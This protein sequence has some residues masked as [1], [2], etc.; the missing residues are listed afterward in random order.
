MSISRQARKFQQ[1]QSGFGIVEALVAAVI[2]TLVLVGVHA[3]TTQ[4]LILVHQSTKR[5]QAAFLMEETIEALRSKRDAGWA[6]SIGTLSAGTNY[7][8]A[9][10]GGVWNITT[11][12]VF[13]DKTFE[14]KFVI[15]DV[16]RDANDD[17]AASGTLDP[18]TKKITATVS[19]YTPT[20][21]TTQSISTYVTNMFQN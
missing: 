14:Q 19:W 21:T 9:F 10:T 16:N 15:E 20:G 17:I 3:T 4:A 11:T 7:Y 1:R 13:V 6:S 2:I 8:L 5:T 18:N 12:N